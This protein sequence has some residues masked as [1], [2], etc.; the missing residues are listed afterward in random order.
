MG[1]LEKLTDELYCTMDKVD[2]KD[3][4]GKGRQYWNKKWCEYY[5]E[6]KIEDLHP[7]LDAYNIANK[8]LKT[9]YKAHY[10]LNDDKQYYLRWD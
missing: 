3:F 2:K 4:F 9:L 6:S 5:C 10:N 7:D 8:K 1:R